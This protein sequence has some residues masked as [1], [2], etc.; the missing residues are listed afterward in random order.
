MTMKIWNKTTK[1]ILLAITTACI[2]NSCQKELIGTIDS[3]GCRVQQWSNISAT[4]AA[5]SQFS[6]SYDSAT[7]KATKLV[8]TDS[9]GASISVTPVIVGDTVYF[10]AGTYAVLDG[11]SRI[12]HLIEKNAI[13]SLSKNGDYYY[14]YDPT[15]HLYKRT[16]DD[17]TNSYVSNLTFSGDMLSKITTPSGTVADV[18]QIAYTYS[19]LTI[20]DFNYF[21]LAKNFPELQFYLPCFTLGAFTNYAIATANFSVIVPVS[22]QPSYSSVFSNYALTSQGYIDSVGI[23]TT[24]GSSTVN[25]GITASYLC[26]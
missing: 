23:Q 4:G 6:Y 1:T 8:Y 12:T 11:S 10:A 19:S 14:Q 26:K 24:T 17:G 7:A 16:Y 3:F 2:L 13:A 15:G 20:T 21:M 5:A 22:N 9:T 25:T 18:F